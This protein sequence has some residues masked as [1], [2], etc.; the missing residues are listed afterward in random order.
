MSEV[1]ET[2]G[3]D[4]LLDALAEYAAKANAS[5][6]VRRTLTGWTCRISEEIWPF[7]QTPPSTPMGM[8]E[9]AWRTEHP[10]S[11]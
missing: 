3:A 9:A 8:A 5:P 10:G 7:V 4:E 2:V 11:E 6:R 1:R